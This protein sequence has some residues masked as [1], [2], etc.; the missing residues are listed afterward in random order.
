MAC[1]R[2]PEGWGEDGARIVI[3]LWA[4]ATAIL[5]GVLL[6]TELVSLGKCGQSCSSGLVWNWQLGFP[7]LG[8]WGWGGDNDG[9]G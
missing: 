6:V 7:S 5:S 3:I 8:G 9:C 1:C 2:E 4:H